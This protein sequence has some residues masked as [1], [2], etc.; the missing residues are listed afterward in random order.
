[1]RS[2]GLIAAGAG[3]DAPWEGSAGWCGTVLSLASELPFPGRHAPRLFLVVRSA[4]TGYGACLSVSAVRRGSSGLGVVVRGAGG[5]CKPPASWRVCSGSGGAPRAAQ[6]LRACGLLGLGAAVRC[7]ARRCSTDIPDF[8]IA[9]S[10]Q[11]AP[12]PLWSSA[13]LLKRVF[14]SVR[15]GR[16]ERVYTRGWCILGAGV[17]SGPKGHRPVLSLVL[18]PVPP[19]L[20]MR[21][22]PSSFAGTIST[23]S[24]HLLHMSTTRR[25]AERSRRT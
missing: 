8:C 3:L 12:R 4:L 23:S 10:L 5:G 11:A 24:W 19:L 6:G 22:P 20:L 7:S 17:Y 13:L 14:R 16:A 25:A 2:A 21:V 15:R 18:L 1:M 9:L